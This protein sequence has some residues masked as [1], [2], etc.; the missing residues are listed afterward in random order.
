MEEAYSSQRSLGCWLNQKH[1][2]PEKKNDVEKTGQ[3]EG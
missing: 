2:E 3:V 1:I